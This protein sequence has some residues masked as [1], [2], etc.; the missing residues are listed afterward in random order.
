[1]RGRERTLK[2]NFLCIYLFFFIFALSFISVISDKSNEI[3]LT[4]SDMWI[5]RDSSHTL[6]HTLYMCDII[7]LVIDASHLSRQIKRM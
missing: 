6:S 4:P 1:V 2:I 5:A 7:L 3:C